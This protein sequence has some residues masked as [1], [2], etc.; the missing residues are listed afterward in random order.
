MLVDN[1][2]LHELPPFLSEVRKLE[3]VKFS[4]NNLHF[5]PAEVLARDWSSIK[6]YLKQFMT[7]SAEEKSKAES[8]TLNLALAGRPNNVTRAK[9]QVQDSCKSSIVSTEE[10]FTDFTNKFRSSR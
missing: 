3:E 7:S 1:N 5:P 8:K 10:N 9:V 6:K 2:L 4:G